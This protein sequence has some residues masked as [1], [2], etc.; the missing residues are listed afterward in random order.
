MKAKIVLPVLL[1]VLLCFQG[2]TRT[3]VQAARTVNGSAV[4]E[5]DDGFKIKAVG[6]AP[7]E[8][9][10]KNKFNVSIVIELLES[11]KNVTESSITIQLVS[12]SMESQGLGIFRTNVDNVGETLA[13]IG[14]KVFS[15]YAFDA[16]KET[17]S[18]HFNITIV[19]IWEKDQVTS[20]SETYSFLIPQEGSIIVSREQIAPLIE[21]YG[22]PDKAAF[23]SWMRIY[24]AWM[25]IMVLPLITIGVLLL[26]IRIKEKRS[27][28]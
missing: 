14:D 26:V 25:S 4:F 18:F 17:D 7:G 11:P 13:V 3:Q 19:L 1:V 6:S 12:Y 2:V 16:P 21:L 22:F 5:I 24:L 20:E 15:S 27:K 9:D 23:F 10:E 8:W 28:K